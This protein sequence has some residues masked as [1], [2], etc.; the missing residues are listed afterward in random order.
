MKSLGNN[1]KINFIVLIQKLRINPEY[2]TIRDILKI[3]PYI[4]KTNLAKMF[5]EEFNSM[6]KAL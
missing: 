1:N 3:K 2:R 4:E 6:I 5:N